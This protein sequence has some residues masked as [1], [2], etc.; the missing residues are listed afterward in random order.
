[1]RHPKHHSAHQS[2][3]PA[4]LS[5]R[6]AACGALACVLLLTVNGCSWLWPW[7]GG[8]PSVVVDGQT[9]SPEEVS[10]AL[11]D[12]REKMTLSPEEPYWPYR[13]GE[14][15]AATDSTASA[16]AYL[17]SALALDPDYA[18]AAALQ[19][20]L[21]YET[22]N[23]SEA[24]VLLEGFL[25]RNADA[26]DALRAALALHLEALGDVERA[27]AVL[28]G[29]SGNSRAVRETRTF[30]SLRGD[31]AKAALDSAKRALDDNPKSAVNH[32][33]YGI[34]LLFAGRPV[35]A[36][37]SF[38][39]ALDLNERLPGA[40]YNMAIVEAFYFFDEESGRQR[41]LLGRVLELG[42]RR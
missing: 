38:L 9:A 8:D 15:Y 17:Q 40:L 37:K 14:L 32:N 1:M 16:I 33:K 39:A 21:Y 26:P 27:Q 7:S 22:A 34:A 41:V 25:S 18:P 29:C 24:V 3:A 23:Y 6:R 30:V 13:V 20:K 19:S 10:A 5:V 36:R 35:E 31:D 2:P 42:Q 28:D 4:G 11:D 12:A